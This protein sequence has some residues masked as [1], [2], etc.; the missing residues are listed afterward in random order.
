MADV[1]NLMN[2]SL[3]PMK[4]FKNFLSNAVIGSGGL[5]ACCISLSS[6]TLKETLRANGEAAANW[7]KSGY[8]G[9]MNYLERMLDEKIEPNKAFPGA[10]SVIVITFDNKWGTDEAAHPF[11]EPKNTELLGYLSAYAKE[12]DY[13]RTGHEVLIK[14]HEKLQ[15]ELGEFNA[16]PCVDTKPVFERVLAVFGGLGI[17]GP[18]DLLRAPKENVRVFIGSL[19]CDIELPEVIHQVEMPFP[20]KFCNNC[21]ENCPTGA[22]SPGKEFDSPKCISYLTIEK[23]GILNKKERVMVEDWLFGCDWCTVVCPPKDKVDT[24]IP[25]D[26]EW[27]LKSSAGELRRIMKGTACEYAGVT[28]LRRNAIAILKEKDTPAAKGLLQWAKEN[29]KS[30]LVLEQIDAD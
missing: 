6:P 5:N 18:N 8:A 14:L 7:I 25:I 16:V 30:P 12:Q 1:K 2:Q 13:H 23:K 4:D 22:L 20:C 29:L 17:R 11:P 26:L 24:R 15:E 10:K 19:F 9:D 3:L 27:L 21:V 28:K